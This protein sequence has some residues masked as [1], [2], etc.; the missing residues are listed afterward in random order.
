M[1]LHSKRMVFVHIQRTGGNSISAALGEA[2]N[3]PD[4]HFSASELRDKCGKEAWNSYFKFSFVRNPW[5]RLVSWW[6]LIETQRTAYENGAILNNNFQTYILSQAKD[7]EQFITR[8]DQEIADID[9]NKSVYK[10]Q[11]DSLTDGSGRL[12]VDF[13]GRFE[14]LQNDFSF[15]TEKLLG[16]AVMLQ[17]LNYVPRKHYCEYYTPALKDL[18][19]TRYARD[20]KAFGYTFANEYSLHNK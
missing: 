6:S 12:L 10:N 5:D 18:V 8:C 20:I 4:K 7:F 19:G 14:T 3:S 1:I 16:H 2:N 9:G 17:R 11:M 13:V 15:V